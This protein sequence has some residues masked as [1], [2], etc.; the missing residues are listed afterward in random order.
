MTVC[1][2]FID[3]S[4]NITLLWITAFGAATSVLIII[5][6]VTCVLAVYRKTKK[7][8]SSKLYG[9]GLFSIYS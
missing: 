5:L 7:E 9:H 2:C 3:E 1:T 8:T 6:V 4:Q